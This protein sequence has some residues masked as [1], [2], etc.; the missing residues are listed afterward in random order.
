MGR[1]PKFRVGQVV[2]C[3]DWKGTSRLG[4]V[5]E[6]IR[7]DDGTFQYMVEWNL[8]ER[9]CANNRELRGL[10]KRERGQP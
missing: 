1:K 5:L 4:K 10:T 6:I 2:H 3:K 8:P 9:M 7:H